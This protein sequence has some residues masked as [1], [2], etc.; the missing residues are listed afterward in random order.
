ML[1]FL[2]VL[3]VTFF[4]LTLYS[5]IQENLDVFNIRHTQFF[6]LK[7]L[8][9][10][11][12]ASLFVTMLGALLVRNQFVLGLRPRISYKSCSIIKESTP[13]KIWQVK[14]YNS[15]LGGAI[16]NRCEF[17]LET[18]IEKSGSLVGFENVVRHLGNIGLVHEEDYWL[19]NISSGFTLP[20]KED[21][22]VF[23][24]KAAH[25]DK[26]KRLNMLLHFQGFLGDKYYRSVVLIPKV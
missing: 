24:I 20:P 23:E 4:G 7:I 19:E 8:N 17:E 18:S 10:E 14:L 3:T 16:I 12:S 21:Y 6:T 9:I 11:S 26:I 2:V 25:I 22:I 1:V 5:I 15:G 13:E